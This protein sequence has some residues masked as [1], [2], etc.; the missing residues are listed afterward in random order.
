MSITK[1]DATHSFNVIGAVRISTLD[2]AEWPVA[3]VECGPL[4]LVFVHGVELV[5]SAV[6]RHAR[7]DCRPATHNINLVTGHTDICII[8]TSYSHNH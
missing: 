6:I 1:D 7:L 2:A 8:A 4:Q 3:E 5:L